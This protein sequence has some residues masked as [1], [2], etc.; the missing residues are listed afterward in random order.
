MLLAQI[1]SQSVEA[2][3]ERTA[4]IAARNVNPNAAQNVGQNAV[5]ESFLHV[6]HALCPCGFSFLC[7]F[8]I[9]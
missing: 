4:E 6:F 7:L 5:E 1:F 8:C 3:V 9:S 2:D